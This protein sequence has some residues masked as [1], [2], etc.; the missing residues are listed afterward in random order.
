[1][2]VR[3]VLDV[4]MQELSVFLSAV[5]ECCRSCAIEDESRSQLQQFRKVINAPRI[6]TWAQTEITTISAQ[7]IRPM[8]FAFCLP[9]MFLNN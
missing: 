2:V 5:H 4:V 6:T 9:R 3:S 1:M 8:R 7:Q